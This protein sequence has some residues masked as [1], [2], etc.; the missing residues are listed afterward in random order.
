MRR[1]AETLVALALAAALHLGL[2]ALLP[3]TVGA[4]ATSSGAAGDEVVSL[5]PA[6]AALQALVAA[7]ETPPAVAA[8]EPA[9]PPAPVVESAPT[10]PMPEM[11]ALPPL[12]TLAPR[13]PPPAAEAPPRPDTPPEPPAPPKPKPATQASAPL[14]ERK[15]AGSGGGDAAG[16]SGAAE[17]AT[18]SQSAAQAA[19]AEWGA[20]IRARIERRMSAPEGSAGRVSLLLRV[21]ADGRLISVQVAQS[22]GDA[23]LD[24]AAL[25]A[26]ARVGR[27]PRA[28]QGL[29]ETS[30][31]I[32]LRVTP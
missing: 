24:Q 29:G 11:A 14:P 18:L 7:W 23:A 26:V 32:G 21:G 22:S 16:D 6:D 28:P 17:A 25:K 31:T 15:A 2:L 20:A 27:F 9:P 5:A 1:L 30:F 10:A 19:R 4:S 3:V 13:D 12:Q 8:P